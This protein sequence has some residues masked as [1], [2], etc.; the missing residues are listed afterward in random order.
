MYLRRRQPDAVILMHRLDHVVD[1]LLHERVAE[2]RLVER[3]GALPEHGVPHA[4]D[5]QDRHR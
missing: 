3:L 1:Q 5:F 4:R 2:G